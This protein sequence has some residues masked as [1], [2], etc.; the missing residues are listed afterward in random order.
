MAKEN[1]QRRENTPPRRRRRPRGVPKALA[2]A[3]IVLALI[4]GGGLGYLISDRSTS[5]QMV[6]RDA[7]LANATQRIQDLES[8]LTQNGIDPNAAVFDDANAMLD[9]A[10]VDALTGG[11]EPVNNNDAL[12]DDSDSLESPVATAAPSVVAEF[13][14]VQ[15]MSNEV[16]DA[17]NAE[18]NRRL[19]NGQDVSSYADTLMEET[20]ADIV[21]ERVKYA[22]AQELGLTE[23]SEEDVAAIEES[24][25]ALYEQDLAFYTVNDG[26]LTQE[27]A[28]AQAEELMA[29]DGM[30]LDTY[31]DRVEAE[32][33]EEKLREYATQDVTVDD[34]ALQ[35][36]YEQLLAE[37]QT[38]YTENP[39]QY[40]YARRYDEGVVVYNPEGYRTFKQVLIAFEAEDGVRVAEILAE[41]EALDATA[42]A[43][44]IAQLE[45]ELDTLYAK[46]E[47]TAE[48]VL[49]RV[50]QG[51]SF[52]ALIEE[53]SQDPE[54]E[55]ASVQSDG[56]Y[57]SAAST[58]Y[59][60]AIKQ[61]VM[62]LQAP[63]D[64]SEQG[65]RSSAGLHVLYYNADVTAGA[66]PLEDVRSALE[67]ETLQTLRYDAYEAQV[68]QWVEEAEVVY[69]REAL[70]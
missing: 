15:I 11:D 17:Y 38:A 23:L 13:G 4:V 2:I 26:T 34:A 12:L 22:K 57:I 43:D 9:A 51:A 39:D 10:T 45:A 66:V 18:V 53:Y 40:E 32:W 41:M 46:L 49:D 70:Q 44:A 60:E 16:L 8:L 68:A 31:R 63:G 3:L 35:A 54:L 55:L 37:Q 5:D 50:A 20:L 7:Q 58:A 52:D 29:S 14:D 24:A 47:P 56:Y 42:D 59:D 30:T 6:E 69:H 33:W 67:A 64:V 27:E 1:P 19:L 36:S 28:R 61:A 62:A 21:S 25:Q 48:E 65:I